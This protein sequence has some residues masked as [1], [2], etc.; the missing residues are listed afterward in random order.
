MKAKARA[1][2]SM[3]SSRIMQIVPDLGPSKSADSFS[4]GGQFTKAE[5][6]DVSYKSMYDSKKKEYGLTLDD[7]KTIE[8]HRRAILLRVR[9]M[10]SVFTFR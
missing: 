2:I 10:M 4:P 9:T 3:M 5:T 6:D 1:P 7:L 8:M